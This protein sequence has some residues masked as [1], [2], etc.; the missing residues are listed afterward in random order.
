MTS[1]LLTPR[2]ACSALR[3]S[4]TTLYHLMDSG[5]LASLKIGKSRRIPADAVA[6]FIRERLADQ[7]SVA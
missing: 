6:R 1:Q 4:R 5:Q 7:A 2:E 3:T